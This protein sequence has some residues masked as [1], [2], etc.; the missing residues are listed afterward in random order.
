MKRHS[1]PALDDDRID[2]P[3]ITQ[4]LTTPDTPD[5]TTKE[6]EGIQ[7]ELS[8]F[9]LGGGASKARK[10]RNATPFEGSDTSD[11][12]W[13]L[14]PDMLLARRRARAWLLRTWSQGER[15]A[16]NWDEDLA[17]NEKVRQHLR[18]RTDPW[19]DSD[20]SVDETI[21]KYEATRTTREAFDLRVDYE[22]KRILDHV[23]GVGVDYEKGDS[24]N[25]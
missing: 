21:A 10:T 5:Q 19:D 25:G 15:T 4:A 3:T 2:P 9:V 13:I 1:S 16:L 12:L 11:F 18:D 22:Y 8:R 24:T 14:N 7:E 17:F 20:A 23:L 6:L